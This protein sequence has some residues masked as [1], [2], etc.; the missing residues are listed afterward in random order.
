MEGDCCL[1]NNAVLPFGADKEYVPALCIIASVLSAKDAS[2]SPESVCNL[3]HYTGLRRQRVVDFMSNFVQ[4]EQC[5]IDL[6]HVCSRSGNVVAATLGHNPG[7][8][9]IPQ[10]NIVLLTSVRG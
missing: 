4:G 2:I 7:D 10:L 1:L 9:F 6:T 3:L 5:A 8:D